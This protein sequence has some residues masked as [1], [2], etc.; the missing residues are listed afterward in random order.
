[1]QALLPRWGAAQSSGIELLSPE[2][3]VRCYG[4]MLLSPPGE[5][6][7]WS[8]QPWGGIGSNYHQ[9]PTYSGCLIHTVGTEAD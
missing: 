8:S 6:A 7:H 5:L 4:W 9:L 2:E 3:R 1:M